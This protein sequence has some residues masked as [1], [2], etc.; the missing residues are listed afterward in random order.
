MTPLAFAFVA[1]ASLNPLD[2]SASLHP[3]DLFASL[4]TLRA[5]I[6][7]DTL[8]ALARLDPLDA[9]AGLDSLDAF[10]R[11]DA[12]DA[13][14]AEVAVLLLKIRILELHAAVMSPVEFPVLELPTTT[15]VDFVEFAVER[16]VRL[17]RRKPTVS[18]IVVVPQRWPHEERCTEPKRRPDRPQRRI[19]E[20]WHVC[21]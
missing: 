14:A 21:R 15:D 3:L 8:D 17:D 10:A 11:L 19:P 1:L 12:L 20:E 2:A 4:D 6:G 5:F 13:F 9:L 7:L 16:G 18:P